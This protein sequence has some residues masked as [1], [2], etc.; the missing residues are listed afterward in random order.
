MYHYLSH[1]YNVRSNSF[2]QRNHHQ[3][4]DSF[5]CHKYIRFVFFYIAYKFQNKQL[6]NEGP[7]YKYFFHPY[8][9][10]TTMFFGEFI[11]LGGYFLLKRRNPEKY[12]MSMLE[13]RSKGKE[14]NMNKFLLAI[15]AFCD[16]VNSTLQYIS[17]N[18]ISGSVYQMLR[19]GTIITTTL[20]SV[21]FLKVK[22]LRHQYI[23][24]ALAF[25]GVF[26]VGFS[27]LIFS[28]DSGSG[29]SKVFM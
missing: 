8:M 17:L 15:P 27:S 4:N 19:G 11:V 29:A 23:G 14:I 13:A 24:C 21:F 1:P 26:I 5:W 6:L 9:Q 7:Y 20:L 3:L 2:I 16:F 22:I 18:F 25:I 10:A 28:D 12:K